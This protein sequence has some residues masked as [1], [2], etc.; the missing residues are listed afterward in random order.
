[1]SGKP[2]VDRLNDPATDVPRALQSKLTELERRRQTLTPERP[3]MQAFGRLLSVAVTVPED[4][5]SRS[6]RVSSLNTGIAAD[7]SAKIESA[8]ALPRILTALRAQNNAFPIIWEG[9][10]KPTGKP[11][12]RIYEI[13]GTWDRKALADGPA[14]P[15]GPAAAAPSTAP[16][17]APA[18]ANTTAPPLSAPPPANTPKPV[19]P[20]STPDPA[21]GGRP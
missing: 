19:A 7:F 11:D 21:N 14:K 3:V 12:E 15:T 4:K 10:P 18:A 6:I 1:D 2:L 8:D 9:N 16:R 20:P 5:L 13:R 17:P